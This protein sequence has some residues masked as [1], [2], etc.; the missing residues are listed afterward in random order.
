MVLGA[1]FSPW[2]AAGWVT[3]VILTSVIY[4]RSKGKLL[5]RPEFK[6]PLFLETWRS[7]NSRRSFITRLGGASNCLWVAVDENTLWVAPHFPFNLM[8]LPEVYGLEFNVSGDAIRSVERAGGLLTGKRV[9]INV[10]LQSGVE[11]SFEVVLREPDA[12]IRAIEA[13]RGR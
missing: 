1:I 11:E 6:Q 8:F 9:R 12:F 3:L 5:F 7:G 4:R 2:F 10:E 13:I